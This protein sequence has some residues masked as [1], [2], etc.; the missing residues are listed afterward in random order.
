MVDLEKK[1]IF[2]EPSQAGCWIDGA[3][4]WSANYLVIEQA[5]EYGMVLS[6]EEINAVREYKVAHG[7]PENDW[8]TGQ[9][10]LADKAS[11]HL[12]SLAPEGYQFIWRDGDFLLEAVEDTHYPEFYA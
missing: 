12:D 4:G 8:V 5:V 10:D 1:K 9:G 3:R 2:V 6:N 11:E 7:N